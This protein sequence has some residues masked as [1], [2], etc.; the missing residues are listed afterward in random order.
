MSRQNVR[1]VTLAVMLTASAAL[2]AQAPPPQLPSGMPGAPPPRDTSQKTGT[3][4][5]RGHVVAADSGQPLRKAQVRAMAPDLRENRITS[6][7]ADGSVASYS[8]NF[9]DGATSTGQN[10]SHSYAASGTFTV[11]LTV[12]DNQGAQSAPA[13]KTVTMSGGNPVGPSMSL[14]RAY[15]RESSWARCL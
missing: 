12:T 7:D 3:A 11:T 4:R 8:W 10:P 9:G 13:S 1:L 15:S 2:L 14:S 5:I 6:T